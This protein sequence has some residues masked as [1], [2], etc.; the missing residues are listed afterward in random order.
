MLKNLYDS[1]SEGCLFGV[2]VWGNKD[3]NNLML[4]IRDS[5]L[6]NGF[7]LPEMRS[8]FHLYDKVP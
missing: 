6:E 8:N 1:A 5:I 4:A 3:H 2:N 7:K